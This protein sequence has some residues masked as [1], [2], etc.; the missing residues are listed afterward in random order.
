MD[1]EL[2]PYNT[3]LSKLEAEAN[4]S[5]PQDLHAL[6]F[7]HFFRVIGDSKPRNREAFGLPALQVGNGF[8]EA[9]TFEELANR[10]NPAVGEDDVKRWISYWREADLFH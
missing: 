1:V 2:V 4:S 8:V 3:W 10:I 9:K 6:R 5:S 7:L